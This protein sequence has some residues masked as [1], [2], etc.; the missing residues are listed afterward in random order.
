MT[1][2]KA[3]SNFHTV[4]KAQNEEKVHMNKNK[5]VKFVLILLIFKKQSYMPKHLMQSLV[6]HSLAIIVQ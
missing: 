4:S 1:G 3:D 2:N 5:F 6:K